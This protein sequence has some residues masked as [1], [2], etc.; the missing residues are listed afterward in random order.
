MKAVSAISTVLEDL[1]KDFLALAEGQTDKPILIYG[2][3]DN[4]SNAAPPGVWWTPGTET[5]TPPQRQGMA[6]F[7]RSLWVR[8]IP[9][10]LEVFGGVNEFDADTLDDPA[11]NL[12]DLDLTEA[13]AML[14]ANS[15]QRRCSQHGHQLKGGTWGQSQ[16]TGIGMVFVLSAVLRLPVVAIDNPVTRYSEIRTTAVITHEPQT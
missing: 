16:Q 1:F 14:L 6:G 13:L 4:Q 15:F 10:N 7:P 2:P 5:W 3:K 11:T 9:I 12:A 8:E